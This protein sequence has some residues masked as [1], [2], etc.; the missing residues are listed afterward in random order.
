VDSGVLQDSAEIPDAR[1]VPADE[2]AAADVAPDRQDGAGQDAPVSG[3]EALAEL[4]SDAQQDGERVADAAEVGRDEGTDHSRDARAE[5]GGNAGRADGS[6]GEIGG[7]VIACVAPACCIPA[8]LRPEDIS[9][10]ATGGTLTIAMFVTLGGT[11]S[12]T[13]KAIATVSVPGGQASCQSRPVAASYA[14]ALIECPAIAL[15]PVPACGATMGIKVRLG[16]STLSQTDGGAVPC[17]GD[18]SVEVERQL[19]VVCPVCPASPD[20]LSRTPCQIVGQH[21]TYDHGSPMET[22][23][24]CGS[25]YTTGERQWSCKAM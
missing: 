17:S 25:L 9:I 22:V 19:P 5:A 8:D 3:P 18:Q 21:C 16:T 10:D 20:G 7:E 11:N 6:S 12:Q 2:V 1:L 24:D 13:W 23:C 14:Y 4:G 15:D